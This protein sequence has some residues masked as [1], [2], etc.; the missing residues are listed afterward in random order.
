M[1][2]LW[3]DQ[4]EIFFAPGRIDRVRLSRGLK[5][6]ISSVVT[7]LIDDVQGGKP[8]WEKP[9]QQLEQML[10]DAA[11]TGM[12]VTLSNHYVRYITLPPQSEI[13]TPEEVLAYADFRMREVYGAHVDQ[14]ILSVS[15]WNP[16]YGAICAA[17]P[18]GLWAQLQEVVLRHKIKLNTVEPYLTAVLDRWSKS[19]NPEKTYLALVETGRI[20][21]GLLQDGIW[22]S[23]RNQRVSQD[24]P[25]ALWAA[26]DQEAVLSGQKEDEEQVL[27]FAPEHPS[28]ALPQDCGWKIVPLQT[29]KTTVPTHYPLPVT[30]RAGEGVCPA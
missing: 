3:R 21:V 24:Y 22:K 26:L 14:W 12:T 16:L 10:A 1:S 8:V 29:D 19:L 2:R 25:D 28:L 15:Q 20:C 30:D 11:G 5:P 23:I 9:L 6:V 7:E 13:T 17:I 4:V 27:L 18:Q